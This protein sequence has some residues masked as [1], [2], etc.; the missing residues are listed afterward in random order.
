MWMLLAVEA[1]AHCWYMVRLWAAGMRYAMLLMK[2]ILSTV[3]RH[4]KV[5]TP[6]KIED[7]GLKVDILLKSV[8][9]Y[10]VQLEPRGR[11]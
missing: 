3:L 7:L 10:P 11:N 2:T 5:S 4:Y 9:G 8:Q 6:L 1:V